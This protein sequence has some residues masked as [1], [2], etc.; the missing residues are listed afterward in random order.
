MLSAAK[1]QARLG[2]RDHVIIQD[3]RDVAPYVLQ[4][5][6]ICREGTDAT[7]ALEAALAAAL[8]ASTGTRARC[9]RTPP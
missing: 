7:E 1:A 6:L 8:T 9:T 2:G 4:H 3:V 5:R